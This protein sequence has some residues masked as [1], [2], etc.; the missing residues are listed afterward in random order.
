MDQVVL[1]LKSGKVSIITLP[2]NEINSL[3]EA[4][5]QYKEQQQGLETN[6]QYNRIHLAK[7]NT[8]LFHIDLDT[9]AII[10]VQYKTHK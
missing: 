2:R 3:R 1:I 5:I 10:Q 8:E 6:K 4:F 9:V 7:N